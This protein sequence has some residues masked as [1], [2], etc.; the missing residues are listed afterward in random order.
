MKLILNFVFFLFVSLTTLGQTT[1][2]SENFG[3]PVQ[4][5]GLWPTAS[6]YTGFQNY[7]IQTYTGNAD[8]RTTV[9]STTYPGASGNGNMFITNTLNTSCTISGINTTNYTNICLQFAILKTTNGSNGSH[10]AVEY[11]VDGVVWT[12]LSFNLGT[13]S[14]SS[15]VWIYIQPTCSTCGTSGLPSTNNLKLRFRMATV[16]TGLQFRIDDVKIIGTPIVVLPIEMLYF[17]CVSNTLYWATASE[18]NTDKFIIERSLDANEWT[19][20][21][22]T[23]AMGNSYYTTRYMF[24]DDTKLSGIVFYRLKEIDYDGNITYS[25]IVGVDIKSQNTDKKTYYNIL[26]V[27]VS[28]LEPNTVYI[29]L[30][31]GNFKKFITNK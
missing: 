6:S 24:I 2:F 27:E 9:P 22:E 18:T 20:I 31:D 23:T 10:L 25:S 7:G 15:N 5:G 30:S 12:A 14:G 26:C 28:N 21:G 3:T 4:V 19:K 17:K 29:E 16:A 13:G 11:S 1:I 8:F